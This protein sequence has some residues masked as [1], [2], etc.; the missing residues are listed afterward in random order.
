[1]TQTKQRRTSSTLIGQVISLIGF[2]TFA[3]KLD[4]DQWMITELI[5]WLFALIGTIMTIVGR[6]KADKKLV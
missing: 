1:M 4:V 2:V 6:L 5:Q 3:L